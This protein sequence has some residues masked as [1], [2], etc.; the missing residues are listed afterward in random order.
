ML[1]HLR[2]FIRKCRP[3]LKLDERTISSLVS[4]SHRGQLS[5]CHYYS[6][7]SSKARGPNGSDEMSAL[8]PYKSIDVHTH[9]YLPR[10]MEMLRTR[11]DVPRVVQIEEQDRL[12]ILPGESE[13]LTTASG[14]P[15]ADEYYSV[16][17]KLKF[18]DRHGIQ[19]SIIS[20]ANPWLDFIV[21]NNEAATLASE[22]NDEMESICSKSDGRLFGFHTVALQNASAATKELD[23]IASFE[24]SRGIIL[25]TMLRKDNDTSGKPMVWLDDPSLE[26]FFQKIAD[27]NLMIFIHPHYGIGNEHYHD[28]GHA[29]FLAL[30]FP[31]ETTVCMSRLI[32]SGIFDRI[33]NLKFL[34]AHSGGTLPFLAG[35]LDSCVMSDPELIGKLKKAP[36]EYLKNFYY[37]CTIYHNPGLQAAIDLVGSDRI[38]F[39]TD[40]PFFPPPGGAQSDE[41][42]PSTVKNYDIL[43]RLSHNEREGM[44]RENAKRILD[45]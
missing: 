19:K 30:G 14:R 23:R 39:G 4:Q 15:I 18:M 36:S 33:P 21:S 26:E 3:G 35:R 38:M 27:L 37:D 42:W 2:N 16:E 6:S 34:V 29:L 22:I 9:M 11:Q 28:A 25:G 8:T 44:L 13:N 45:L 40:N 24:H 32:V 10:Y 20:L 17:R 7:S 41:A 12:I 5:G 43:E 1:P 31:F